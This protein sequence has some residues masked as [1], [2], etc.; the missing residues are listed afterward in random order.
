[1]CWLS[2]EQNFT[3]CKDMLS[4]RSLTRSG[5]NPGRALSLPTTGLVFKALASGGCVD[6]IGVS[7]RTVLKKWHL[8]GDGTGY[9]S[10]TVAADVTVVSK[11]GTGE[12][13]IPS[14][15]RINVGVGTLWSLVLSNGSRYEH[16][17][18]TS[19]TT[20]VMYDVSGNGRHLTLTSYT[21]ATAVVESLTTGSDWLNQI[22]WGWA[23][24]LAK[25]SRDLT[26]WPANYTKGT[27]V[28]TLTYNASVGTTITFLAGFGTTFV[29]WVGTAAAAAYTGYAKFKVANYTGFVGFRFFNTSTQ[30][31][32]QSYNV[33]DPATGKFVFV[34]NGTSNAVCYVDSEGWC[35]IYST[36][37][38]T[39]GSRRLELCLIDEYNRHD[40][41]DWTAESTLTG[42]EI[43]YVSDMGIALGDW[44]YYHPTT[45]AAIDA[46][47]PVTSAGLLVSD[48]SA[49]STHNWSIKTVTPNIACWGDSLTEGKTRLDWGIYPRML[50]FNCPGRTVHNGGYGGMEAQYIREQMELSP[51]KYGDVNVIWVGSN[52]VK[53]EGP[54]NIAGRITEV[55]SEIAIMVGHVQSAGG[56]YV[57]ITTM[58]NAE[59]SDEIGGYTVDTIN[60]LIISTYPN[61]HI[62]MHTELA[63]YNDGSAED[64]ADIANGLVPRSLRIHDGTLEEDP[65][66]P[67]HWG[68]T[69]ISNIVWNFINTNLESLTL[70]KEYV[71]GFGRVKYSLKAD[72]SW[73]SAPAIIERSGVDN[74]V[75]DADGVGKAMADGAAALAAMATVADDEY[76]FAGTKAAVLYDTINTQVARTKRAV[77]DTA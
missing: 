34:V 63:P 47:V 20:A 8:L 17:T 37:A 64:M 75:Y 55:M 49:L 36:M 69:L 62:V 6:T 44:I 2:A 30:D 59:W 14:A 18:M 16:P 77:G 66:H 72:N 25:P 3:T 35:H 52:N 48:G 67:N 28:N 33:V 60:D 19:A 58:R 76:L 41:L 71:G 21:L 23:Q 15:N 1:M 40:V 45:S 22:G 53:D 61:N 10:G 46:T 38:A 5:V 13:T 31:S 65:I 39:A 74:A 70:Q 11:G 24:N 26:G 7:G 54:E 29:R 12:V 9:L 42:N 73:P 68:Y 51:E 27:V 32:R 57:V 4:S 43:L 50:G 56:K